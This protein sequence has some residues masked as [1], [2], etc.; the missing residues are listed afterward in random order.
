M[1]FNFALIEVPTLGI[2]AFP[3][4]VSE[5]ITDQSLLSFNK[6][7]LPSMSLQTKKIQEGNYPFQ[8]N[9]ILNQVT[10]SEVQ[11]T[12][13]VTS[14]NFDFWQW[15]QQAIYGF[16][17]GGININPR[18]HFAVVQLKSDKL[19]PRKTIVLWDCIPVSYSLDP[20]DASQS[21]VHLENLSIACSR[22]DVIP[23]VGTS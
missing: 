16:A 3:I 22:F 17:P 10:T 19:I 9:L 21:S 14:L 12:Q 11:I 20:L 2:P 15:L 1:S 6:I 4:K 7:Q 8:H 13:A 5:A 23:G 18:R